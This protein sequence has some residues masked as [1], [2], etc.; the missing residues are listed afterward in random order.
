MSGCIEKFGDTIESGI[1]SF[2]HRVGSFVGNAPR[3]TI[4]LCI[5]LAVAMGGG[6]ATWETENRPEELWVPQDTTAEEETSLYESYFASTTRFN[7]I[8][9]QAKGSDN[10]LT[11]EALSNAMKMHNFIETEVVVVDDGDANHKE[12]DDNK[13]TLTEVCVPAGGACASRFDGVCNCLITSILGQWNYDLET[14]ENDANILQ[15]LSGYGTKDDL[16]AVLGNPKFDADGN[17]ESAEAFTLAYFLTSRAYTKDGNEIDPINEAWEEAAFLEGAQAVSKNYTNIEVDYFAA[18]SFSD[19]FGGAITGDLALVQISYILA[20]L[21]LGANLGNLRC[22]NGSRWSMSVAA[23]VTVGLSTAAGFG[24]SSLFGLFFGPVHSLL[25]FILLGIGVDDAF[26]IVNAFNRERKTKRSAED[27]ETLAKRSASSLARAGASITVTSLT[28]LVAF[29]ISS[30][31]ALPALASFCAYAAIS[32]FFLWLFASTFFTACLVLD[33]RRQRDNRRECLCCL[34]RKN[35]LE[36]DDDE[37]FK[38]DL[39]SRYFR[40]YHAPA[41]LSNVGKVIVF[42]VFAGLLGFGIY[43]AMNLSV[44]D[45]ERNF[46]P[47]DSYLNDYFDATDDYF[48]S[49]GIALQIVF[50]ESDKIYASRVELA[51]LK[52]RL[53]G[54]SEKSPYIAEPVSEE[55]YKNVMDGLNSYLAATGTDGIAA[56]MTLGDDNWPTTEAEF[57]TLL[58]TYTE[59]SGP[60]SFYARDVVFNDSGDKLEAIKVNS[61]YVR[62]TKTFRGEILDDADRQIDA[63]EDTRT[64]IAGWTDLPPATPYSEKF[65]SIEGF[66]IIRRELFMNVGLAIAAVAVIVFFTVANPITAILITANVAFCIVEILGF[67]FALG[68]VIDSVSVI[69]IVLAVG[70]SVDYSAH[71]G[72]CFMVKGGDDKNKRSLEAL[73]DIGAAVLSGAIST[74]LAVLV[75]LFSTSYVFVTLSRQ[76][77]LTVILG[78]SHGLILLPVLLAVFG[79]KPFNSANEQEQEDNKEVEEGSDDK[80]GKTSHNENSSEGDA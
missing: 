26:V 40:N 20:F 67:M 49:Q 39:V 6:F 45:S 66:K 19:E 31:S 76:F 79:P 12:G 22:G 46:I 9:V 21:F 62:L 65:L 58:K 33:E 37:N 74:F 30:S 10:V 24:L 64:M 48:P 5:L 1:G 28:D 42:V 29:A 27:N 78:V 44:E 8:I 11:K 14:L 61:E 16:T 36:E 50:E 75:L 72:H 13:Y 47:A 53:S 55:V 59:I 56:N 38:E 41:I 57:V 32:I 77:A 80:A 17:I 3:K 7:S 2:F 15:T 68:I 69:N 51:N 60:G 63:M 18:R 70:L 54:L 71:V 52:S 35:E 23:L 43:G 25:P 34:T 73:A 4:A